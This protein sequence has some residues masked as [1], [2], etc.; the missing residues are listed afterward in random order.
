MGIRFGSRPLAGIP[1]PAGAGL[2]KGAG[3]AICGPSQPGA[4]KRV[5]F[6]F[7]WLTAIRYGLSD[8]SPGL[9]PTA[10]E[11][12]CTG[13]YPF[14]H[15]SGSPS[16]STSD[17]IS[18]A[19]RPGWLR[20]KAAKRALMA[21]AALRYSSSISGELAV[22]LKTRPAILMLIF[23]SIRLPPNRRCTYLSP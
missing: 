2:P 15:L 14:A 11:H 20:E 3:P 10:L 21:S 22:R 12:S 7:R 5:D 19:E 18:R 23:W 13:R 4:L 16:R 8:S 1:S 6:S 9:S 17:R